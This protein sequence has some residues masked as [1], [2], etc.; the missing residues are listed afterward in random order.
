MYYGEPRRN[1]PRTV[2]ET[3]C[4]IGL[5]LRLGAVAG[6]FW[7]ILANLW[8]LDRWTVSAED[9]VGH[10]LP[11]TMLAIV[12]CHLAYDVSLAC[13]LV[14]TCSLHWGKGFL[15]GSLLLAAPGLMFPPSALVPWLLLYGGIQGI[16]IAYLRERRSS[17]GLQRKSKAPEERNE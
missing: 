17:F 7:S 8:L 14:R 10:S 15:L 13:L 3:L 5:G 16:T 2:A 6:L 4:Q 12:V 1:Q 9:L 11:W